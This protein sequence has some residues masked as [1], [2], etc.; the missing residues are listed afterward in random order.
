MTENV[1]NKFPP[2]G[3][4]LC[5]VHSS[6]LYVHL[7]NL[8]EKHREVDVLL[9]RIEVLSMGIFYNVTFQKKEKGIRQVFH[10]GTYPPQYFLPLNNEDSLY[11][12]EDMH[13]YF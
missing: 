13:D 7:E 10:N 11:F 2:I 3:S 4:Q 12:L 8:R 5:I 1:K 9:R 6:P